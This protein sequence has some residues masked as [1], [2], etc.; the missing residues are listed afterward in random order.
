MPGSDA[1]LSVTEV[2]K[3]QTLLKSGTAEGVLLGLSLFES[4]GPVAADV[5]AV[6]TQPVRKAIGKSVNEW[7]QG[8]AAVV[9][10]AS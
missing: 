4:L 10:T 7:L 1:T 3:V 2:R 9:R 6:L 5:D 8:A